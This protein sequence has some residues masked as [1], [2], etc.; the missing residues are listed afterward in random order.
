M[1]DGVPDA[2]SIIRQLLLLLPVKKNSLSPTMQTGS[3][4]EK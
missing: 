4:K 1:I 3:N 2:N